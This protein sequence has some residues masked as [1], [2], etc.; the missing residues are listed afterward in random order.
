MPTSTSRFS[1]LE[2]DGINNG[3]LATVNYI[4]HSKLE[5]ALPFCLPRKAAGKSIPS[6]F[7]KGSGNEPLSSFEDPLPK[8]SV[9]VGDKRFG[10]GAKRLTRN[11]THAAQVGSSCS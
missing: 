3:Q 8:G 9:A 4:A 5:V 7:S 10:L 1:A 2:T 6:P 11:P